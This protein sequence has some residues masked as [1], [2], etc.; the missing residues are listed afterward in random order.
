MK[1]FEVEFIRRS[2][3][4][5]RVIAD[6]YDNAV[7]KARELLEEAFPNENEFWELVYCENVKNKNEIN[8]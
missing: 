8:V 5:Y 7:E 4:D 2:Y 1:T 6:D 3:V